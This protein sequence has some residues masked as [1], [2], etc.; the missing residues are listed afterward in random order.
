MPP[1]PS[2]QQPTCTNLRIRSVEDAHKIFYAIQRGFLRMV[3]RRLD[4]E[5]RAALQTGCVYA[6][7]ERSPNTEITGIGIERFTEGRR[8]SASRVRDEFLFYYEK[9][10][11]DP[12]SNN[13]KEPMGWEQLVKQTYSVWVETEKGKKKWHLTAYFTQSTVDQLGT[14]DDISTLRHLEVPAGL[15]TS[16][17]IGKRKNTD[18]EPQSV[19]RVYAAFPSPLPIAPRPIQSTS[20]APRPPS[21]SVRMYEP[22]SRPPSR[23]QLEPTTYQTSALHYSYPSPQHFP[24]HEHPPAPTATQS[25][26]ISGDFSTTRVRLVDHGNQQPQPHQPQPISGGWFTSPLL[27][28]QRS[29]SPRSE[30]NSSSSS[31][32]SYASS[33]PASLYPLF[34]GYDSASSSTRSLPRLVGL[35]P[36]EP[37]PVAP[38]HGERRGKTGPRDL[39]PLTSLKRTHP[40]S[41]NSTDDRTLRR[42]DQCGASSI[43]RESSIARERLILDSFGDPLSNDLN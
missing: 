25:Y 2:A 6:W 39:A 17:R 42:L 10:V 23:S 5:E 22:Y 16:T 7:E 28:Y 41:R 20:T 30:Y 8:W 40:Y 1:Q 9:W 24:E 4:L 14:V 26:P 18:S 3:S 29:N 32:S 15:F 37:T 27:P 12:N 11:P 33:P 38:I 43:V 19:A 35:L 36:T 13:K 31:S 21:P 34:S